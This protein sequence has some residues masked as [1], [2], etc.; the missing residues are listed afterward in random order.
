MISDR[1]IEADLPFMR[2]V[3]LSSKILKR[4]KHFIPEDGAV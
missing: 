1:R 2:D 4:D 3:R